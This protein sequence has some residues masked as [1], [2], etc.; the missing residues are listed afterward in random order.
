MFPMHQ[1]RVNS[2]VLFKND[3]I[4]NYNDTMMTLC[5]HR[6]DEHVVRR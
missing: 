2:P 4:T 1:N 6:N 3:F 5:T